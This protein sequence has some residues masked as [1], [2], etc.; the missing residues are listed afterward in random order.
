MRV[1]GV[2]ER[3]VPSHVS[4]HSWNVGQGS[5][6]RAAGSSAAAGMPHRSRIAREPCDGW[7]GCQSCE[8]ISRFLLP[9]V[10][11]HHTPKTQHEWSGPLPGV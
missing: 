9:W 5:G 6:E 10:V 4:V 2:S 11:G 1:T 8:R 7:C 3:S